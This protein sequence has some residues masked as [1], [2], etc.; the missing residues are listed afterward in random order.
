MTLEEQYTSLLKNEDEKGL[1]TFLQ[2]LTINDKRTFTPFVKKLGKEY[3]AFNEQN[4]RWTPKAT[5]EQRNLL[6]YTFFVCYNYKEIQKENPAWIL[7]REHLEKILPWYT[8]SWLSDY[9]NSFGNNEWLPYALDYG[10]L[11]N[12]AN[13]GVVTPTPQLIAKM[14][15]PYVHENVGR[16]HVF[17]PDRLEELEVTLKEH[18]WHLFEY[19]TTVHYSNRY[20]YSDGMRVEKGWTD[21]FI[22]F[23]EKEKIDSLKLLQEALL[24][25][26]RNFNKTLSGWYAELFLQLKPTQEQAL[27]LQR[28][29]LNLFSSP[30]SKVVNTALQACKLIVECS[31]FDI[32]SFLDGSSLLLSNNTKSVVTSALQVLERVAKKHV[33]KRTQVCMISTEAFIHKDDG[34]QTRAANLI[35]K[36]A[37][38]GDADLQQSLSL[39]ND[40]LFSNAKALLLPFYSPRLDEIEAPLPSSSPVDG[41]D[42]EQLPAVTA[43][44]AITTLDELVFLSSQAF[45]NNESWHIDLFPASLIR[46]QNQ[47][48]GEHLRM[49]EPAIQRALKLYF[50]DWRST[51]GELDLLL[52]CFFLDYCLWLIEQFPEEGK[53][54][55]ELFRTFLSK[56]EENKK[57]WQEHGTGLT[58]LGGWKPEGSRYLYTAHRKLLE[59]VL[60]GLKHGLNLPLLCEP[61]HSPAFI[62]PVV[63]IKRLAM[64]QD[65]QGTIDETDLQVAIS[66]CWL[67]GVENASTIA[68]ETLEGELQR[69]MLFLLDEKKE[70]VGPFTLESAWMTAALSK[71][72]RKQYP[73]LATLRYSVLPQGK[74]TGQYPFEIVEEEYTLDSYVWKNEK[75]ETIKKAAKRQVIKI[76]FTLP[77]AKNTQQ[78][79]GLKKW[80]KKVIGNEEGKDSVTTLLLSDY[81]VFKEQWLSVEDRDIRR[82][83]MLTPNNPEPLIAKVIDK[84]LSNPIFIDAAKQRLV[85]KVLQALHDTRP[86]FGEMSHLFISTS[87]LSADKTTATYAAEIWLSAVDDRSINSSSIGTLLGKHQC[88]EFAPM[89]RLTDLILTSMLNVS[90]LHNKALEEMLTRLLIH[91]PQSPVKGLKKLLEIYF[92][93]LHLNQSSVSEPALNILLQEWKQSKNLQKIQKFMQVV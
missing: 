75:C 21:V 58:F 16:E 13:R 32:S 44:P 14:L 52:A 43:L 4:G 85:I 2:S 23:V 37:V 33:E 12:L 40:T 81:L 57:V 87:M 69:L 10:Y 51:Q 5:T 20:L 29:I 9:I 88:I 73:A 82:I 80:F 53:T 66:R 60:Y 78:G 11:M 27:T 48:T 56:S 34:I 89:K 55:R 25:S 72:P 7:S 91:L 54:A 79:F 77:A 70:P 19:E 3:S 86:S 63:L 62:D 47:I 26:H 92:E 15:V 64:H 28:E 49:F 84:C 38:I 1:L 17:R 90:S 36:Y 59:A 39:Y 24:A 31:T 22:H 61:T 93:L 74:Y 6:S 35:A 83:F 46:L 45:D 8:P 18:I 71:S 41:L 67:K 42:N 65:Q 68:R 76:D 30:H 50:G